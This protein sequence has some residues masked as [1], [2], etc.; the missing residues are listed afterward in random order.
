M[1]KPIGNKLVVKNLKEDV[2][3]SGIILEKPQEK[4]RKGEVVSI[5]NDPEFQELGIN[6]G[7]TVIFDQYK[8]TPVNFDGVAH[9]VLPIDDL[10]AI[11]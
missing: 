5:S 6:V 2:R 11:L 4:I 1:I 10:M 9:T 8:G 7:D 3:A